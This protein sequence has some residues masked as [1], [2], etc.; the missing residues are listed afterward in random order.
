MNLSCVKSIDD[1]RADDNG[2]WL[3]SGKPRRKY[4]VEFDSNRK[5]I[6]SA[7]VV[8]KE[9]DGSN[10]YTLV[11]IYHRHKATPE[12]QHHICYVLDAVGHTV[13]NVV[14]QYLFEDGVEDPVVLPPH[15]NSKKKSNI[16]SSHPT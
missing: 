12:F 3:H 10:V 11:R 13:Q 1:P 9:S 15:G 14:V 6:I 16:I 7:T 5:E 4:K 8:N 2:V